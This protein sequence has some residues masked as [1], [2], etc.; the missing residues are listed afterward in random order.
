MRDFQPD[1]PGLPEGFR[2]RQAGQRQLAPDDRP[3]DRPQLDQP[4]SAGQR[5]GKLQD[6]LR[7]LARH[8]GGGRPPQRRVAQ[9]GLD[10]LQGVIQEQ[11]E[12]GERL[13]MDVQVQV[14]PYFRAIGCQAIGRLLPQQHQSLPPPARV[15]GDQVEDRR[16]RTAQVERPLVKAVI[17]RAIEERP[18]HAGFRRGTQRVGHLK[19]QVIDRTGRQPQV[20][21]QLAQ[22]PGL[23]P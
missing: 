12:V 8:G 6:Q 21:E 20:E 13:V 5:F 2:Y 10:Q 4:V 22:R 16:G 14:A 1:L 17:R 7:T 19:Q 3:G 18:G 9:L 15:H 11:R 23:P